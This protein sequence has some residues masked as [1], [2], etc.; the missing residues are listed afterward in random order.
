L[1]GRKTISGNSDQGARDRNG[2]GNEHFIGVDHRRDEHPRK[3]D[4]MGG[5]LHV[6]DRQNIGRQGTAAGNRQETA[7]DF[8]P[9]ERCQAE[10][11]EQLDHH[12]PNPEASA[13]ETRLAPQPEP[14]NNRQPAP[15]WAR[16]RGGRRKRPRADRPRN[17][18]KPVDAPIGKAAEKR[19]QKEDDH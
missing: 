13:M 1:R 7:M 18:G 14:A 4:G 8:P 11:A 15:E 16:R 17:P 3:K 12:R 19:S 2:V 9:I 6:N 5:K 10:P